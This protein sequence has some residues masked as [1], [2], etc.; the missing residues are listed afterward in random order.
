MKTRMRLRNDA[1]TLIELLVV[2]SVIALL[3]AILLP[4]LKS[5]RDSARALGCA[6]NLRQFGLASFMYG[7]DNQEVVLPYRRPG[8]AT[9]N[10]NWWPEVLAPYLSSTLSKTPT[11]IQSNSPQVLALRCPGAEN[12]SRRWLS[13]YG[14]TRD[15]DRESPMFIERSQIRSPS[16]KGY[17]ADSPWTAAGDREGWRVYP[18]RIR[19]PGDFIDATGQVAI[20][21]QHQGSARMVFL[22]G[23]AAPFT[24]DMRFPHTPPSHQFKQL[25]HWLY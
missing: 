3:V 11:V 24:E 18:Y 21:M 6:S 25:F 2:I 22:D 17:I 7:E 1:F 8:E 20:L 16:H 15:W 9:N 23:H 10:R 5:A 19:Y 13:T 4:A 12:P 14:M